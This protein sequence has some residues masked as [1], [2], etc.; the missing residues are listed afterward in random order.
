VGYSK[1]KGACRAGD[2]SCRV[3]EKAGQKK[4]ET[5]RG[6][7]RGAC[8][9]RVPTES[10]QYVK[11]TPLTT[12]HAVTPAQAMRVFREDPTGVF[13]FSVTGC[14]ALNT[15]AECW[16]HTG[17]NVNPPGGGVPLD[18]DGLVGVTATRTSMTFTVLEHGY[19]DGPGS[20][21]SFSTWSDSEGTTYLRQTAY[22][23]GG[24]PLVAF[25]VNRFGAYNSTWDSQA[26]NLT[27]E[28]D[29]SFGY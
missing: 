28:I 6:C 16:L 20:T 24:N 11:D 9:P 8:A 2:W 1:P 15:G 29:A 18:S 7:V 3:W 14:D 23:Y 17:R 26:R 25:G 22:A 10:Y 21:I 13:P 4:S 27:R 19:F 12:R 5:P